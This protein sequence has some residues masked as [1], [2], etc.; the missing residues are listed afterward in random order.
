LSVK[1]QRRNVG[2]MMNAIKDG[3]GAPVRALRALVVDDHHIVVEALKT[4]VPAMRAFKR[5]DT[6]SSL[7]QACEI[8]QRDANCQL[9][10]LDLHLT[11]V[12]GRDTL[13]GLRERFPDVP[14]LVFSGDSSLDNMTMAF[15][16]GARGYVTKT[17]PM[18]V[19][20]GAIRLVLSGGTYVP[21]DAM[22]I[23]GM[24]QAVASSGSVIRDAAGSLSPRQQQV[25]QL[26][27]QGMPNKVIAARLDMAEG[28]AKAH[29]NTVFR[30]LGVRTRV[31][32]I[33]RARELGMI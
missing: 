23:L 17:S 28:T 16:C 30:V 29:L 24:P 33:L 15:E 13:I 18:N 21:P 32:A 11:D 31:E 19:V 9:A 25:F 12:Q 14:V 6:A 20:D 7:A 1:E 3:P 4:G 27:L 2:R 5:I 26:L 22:R 10:I 8:L